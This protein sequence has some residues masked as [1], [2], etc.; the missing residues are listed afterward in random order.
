MFYQQNSNGPNARPFASATAADDSFV[1]VV[2]QAIDISI[3]LHAASAALTP[4]V[5]SGTV[6]N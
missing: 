3:D 6:S 2:F 4:E 1:P 5:G